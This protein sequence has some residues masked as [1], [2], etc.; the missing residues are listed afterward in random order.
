M[1]FSGIRAT[2][3]GPS[4]RARRSSTS[5]A[6]RQGPAGHERQA[7]YLA[8]GEG[9]E[10][11]VRGRGRRG[12]PER[13]VPGAARQRPRGARP[14]RGQDAPLPDPHPARATACA[15][16]SRPTTSTARGSSTATGRRSPC[17]ELRADRGDR[18]GAASAARRRASCAGSATTAPWCAP[19]ACAAVSVDVMVDG[20]HFRLGAGRR[21]ADAG[22]RALAGALSDLAA[23]GAEPGEAYLA[24]VLPAGARRRGRARAARGAE[25][26]AARA[27][28]DDRRR[29]PRRRPG[30]DDRGHGRRLGRRRRRARRPRRRAAGRPRRRDR[31]RSAPRPPASRCSTAARRAARRSTRATCARGRGWPRAARWPPPARTRCST[32]PTALALD[33][34]RLAEA[35]RRAARARRGARCR[36]RPASPR[37]P[38]RSAAS[39]AELAATGGEDF[40]LL[41]CV[42]RGGAD[43]APSRPGCH[44]DRPRHGRCARRRL[45]R[46]TRQPRAGAAS[47]ISGAGRS[48]SRAVAT[49]ASATFCGVDCVAVAL[50]ARLGAAPCASSSTRHCVRT[51]VRCRSWY[52]TARTVM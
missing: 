17:G 41:V 3:S 45:A 31:R 15:W 52:R 20:T 48:A 26:L 19:A 21:A 50:D 43:G 32:S 10:G 22:W 40:E 33:A 27:R 8:L 51:G 11:R 12:A 30:A 38:R 35:Q 29:R 9:R 6:R 25:A 4:R 5:S 13:D 23:M 37:S 36:S 2:G 34:R 7:I 39:A 46:A 16:R 18:G 28:R 49:I 14:R 47:S 1:H 44:V 24:V 42:P